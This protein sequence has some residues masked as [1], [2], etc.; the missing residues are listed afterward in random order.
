M[1]L[2]EQRRSTVLRT[3][4]LV[5]E[6]EMPMSPP[7]IMLNARRVRAIDPRESGCLS[8]DQSA[9]V[10]AFKNDAAAPSRAR[11]YVGR[12]KNRAVDFQRCREEALV[13]ALVE[14]L[15]Q[16]L[17]VLSAAVDVIRLTPT[18]E[19]AVI[20]TTAIERQVGQMIRIARDLTDAMQSVRQREVVEP[21]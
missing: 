3:I 4:A 20:A 17:L 11:S 7:A 12:A 21:R 1:F 16:P 15:R 6:I 2:F 18:S 13:S 19:A 9:V 8:T 5:S 14:D 10:L